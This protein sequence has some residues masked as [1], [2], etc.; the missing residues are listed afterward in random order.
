MS[1]SEVDVPMENE[2]RPHKR[3]TA[4]KTAAAT[5]PPV[6]RS[7]VIHLFVSAPGDDEL[8]FYAFDLTSSPKSEEL[9]RVLAPPGEKRVPSPETLKRWLWIK[10]SV[11]DRVPR[12]EV[13][14]SCRGEFTPLFPGFTERDL[15]H[16]TSTSPADVG[17]FGPV[18]V[19]AV[20]S[21]AYKD[22]IWY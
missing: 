1:R 4:Q 6:P 16:W 5:T 20:Y 22:K 8:V 18:V 19:H 14:Q 10:L 2:P 15:G 11:I 17:K 21:F 12:K 9:L 13:V 7:P 3:Y